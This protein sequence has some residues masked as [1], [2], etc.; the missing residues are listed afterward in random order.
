MH[1]IRL[2]VTISYHKVDDFSELY[3]SKACPTVEFL[4]VLDN[5]L[6]LGGLSMQH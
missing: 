4:M 1:D 6:I 3:G 5:A 2:P